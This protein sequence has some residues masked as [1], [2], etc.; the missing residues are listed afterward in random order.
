MSILYISICTY[1]HVYAYPCI[2]TCMHVQILCNTK[3]MTQSARVSSRN[4]RRCN[5][6]YMYAYVLVYAYA[7]TCVYVG[8]FLYMY[9]CM[10]ECVRFRGALIM[11]QKDTFRH[12]YHSGSR[13][14]TYVYTHIHTH[15]MDT[16][17]VHEVRQWVCSALHTHT[18][19]HIHTHKH[20]RTHT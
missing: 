15:K 19:T 10:Q 7:Y 12:A 3:Q 11:S 13:R 9:A 17:S 5:E 14:H 4:I 16:D 8:M 1:A 18:Y 6:L 2:L 20:T